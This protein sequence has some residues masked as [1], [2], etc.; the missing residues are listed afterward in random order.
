MSKGNML[1]TWLP[2]LPCYSP[3]PEHIRSSMPTSEIL[4]LT[5]AWGMSKHGVSEARWAVGHLQSLLLP[6][7]KK[8]EAHH[9]K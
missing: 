7:T 2:P 4:K 1:S 8:A 5:K 6:L 3:S 9:G